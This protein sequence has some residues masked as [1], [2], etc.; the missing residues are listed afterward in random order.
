[1][2]QEPYDRRLSLLGGGERGKRCTTLLHFNFSDSI[3]LLHS[4]LLHSQLIFIAQPMQHNMSSFHTYYWIRTSLMM[5]QIFDSQSHHSY[6]NTTHK[7]PINTNFLT[8]ILLLIPFFLLSSTVDH[9]KKII[10]S[11]ITSHFQNAP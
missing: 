8:S 6:L 4:I 3:F 2:Y 7:H 5:Y 11:V 1:M 9:R 10:L